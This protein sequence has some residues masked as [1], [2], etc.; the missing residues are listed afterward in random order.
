MC[1]RVIS[2]CTLGIIIISDSVA[3]PKAELD[4]TA[5]P[6]PA[7]LTAISAVAVTTVPASIECLAVKVTAAVLRVVVQ[8]GK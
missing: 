6:S 5:S 3:T 2:V 4:T 1:S 8:L 7:V